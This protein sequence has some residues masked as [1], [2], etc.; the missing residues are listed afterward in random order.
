MIHNVV[1][2]T[3]VLVTA[4]LHGTVFSVVGLWF[5]LLTGYHEHHEEFI[6]K[7]YRKATKDARKI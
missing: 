2:S 7:V 5:Q 4:H 6:I 1:G 3:E